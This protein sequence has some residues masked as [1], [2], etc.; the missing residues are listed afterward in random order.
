MAVDSSWTWLS[1][2]V[3]NVTSSTVKDVPQ[4]CFHLRTACRVQVRIQRRVDIGQRARVP[5]EPVH[6]NAGKEASDVHVDLVGRPENHVSG[7]Y[8][9]QTLEDTQL[10][11]SRQGLPLSCFFMQDRSDVKNVLLL[12]GCGS[13][14][15]LLACSGRILFRC[16]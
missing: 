15:H 8:K 12:L 4:S 7:Q 10:F 14:L 3:A 2:R 5:V 11:G 1:L 16:G 6:I 9:R 13:C